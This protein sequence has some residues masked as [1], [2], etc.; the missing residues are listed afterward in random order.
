MIKVLLIYDLKETTK[1]VHTELKKELVQTYKYSKFRLIDGLAYEL[2]NTTFYK[3]FIGTV[4]VDDE[5]I[6]SKSENEFMFACKKVKAEWERVNIIAYKNGIF[7]DV[8]M[9]KV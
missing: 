5:K 2:P 6:I 1:S 7:T 9:K 3:E 4:D 8:N